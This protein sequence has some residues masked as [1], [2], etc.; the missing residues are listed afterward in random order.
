MSQQYEY[1][2]GWVD[3]DP[4]AVNTAMEERAKSGWELVSGTAV[5]LGESPLAPLRYVMYW[6][7]AFDP[8]AAA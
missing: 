5:S 4:A 8:R 2:M 6:R 3:N 1:W 7:R